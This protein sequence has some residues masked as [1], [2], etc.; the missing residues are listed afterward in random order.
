MLQ[1]DLGNNLLPK[2]VNIFSINGLPVLS[3]FRLNNF[4]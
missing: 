3:A 2:F 4:F 1:G